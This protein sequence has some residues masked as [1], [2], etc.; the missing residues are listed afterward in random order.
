MACSDILP[1]PRRRRLL[2]G[3]LA[4]GL[5][6]CGGGGD[7]GT[8]PFAATRSWRM[9]FS[10]N[11]PRLDA[12]TIIQGIDQW[13][14]RAELAVIHEELPWTDLLAGMTPAAILERDKVQL[15]GYLRGKGLQLYVMA[16]PT[17]GLDRAQESPQLRAAGRSLT[18]PAIQ[19]L[20]RDYV[21]A[22]A[23]RLQPE[24]L[25]LAAET[26]L[27]R[28]AAGPALYAALVQAANAAS[29]D[30]QAAGDGATRLVSVQ[31]ETA[32]GRLGGSG[33]YAGIETD[34][35]DF[36][37]LQLLGL[38]S[39]P[40]FS[41]AQP[42]DLPADYYSRLRGARGTPLMVVEGGW[43]SVA[44]GGVD[45]SPAL[46][47]R[48]IRRHAELLDS[49]AARGWLQLLFADIDLAALPPPVPANLPL[50]T[51]IGLTDSDF[52][53]KPAL[54]EWDALHGRALRA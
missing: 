9:G 45:S 50:F 42:E 2:G 27:V 17:D 3:L 33:S 8:P 44:V 38:S 1:D 40:Y 19:Q 15:V 52:N 13:S 53:P 20:Y 23:S 39:Y 41:W 32:W 14:T 4:A 37:F 5:A 25:G 43:S 11:P 35:A 49:V 18:E 6:G 48:Y 29:A 28:R 54:A 51:S 34:Y 24:Y 10:P 46:Q 30:L 47:A 36:P 12:A 7:S 16:D 26:N 22:V 31:V 21:L